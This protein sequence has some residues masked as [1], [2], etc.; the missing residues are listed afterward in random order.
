[1]YSIIYLLYIAKTETFRNTARK[2]TCY[3][4]SRKP[5]IYVR[6]LSFDTFVTENEI[7]CFALN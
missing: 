3:V 4:Y 5:I 6:G 2:I 1:M 7:R